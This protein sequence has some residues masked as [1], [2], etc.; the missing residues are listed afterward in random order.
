MA[1]QPQ[2][3]W[4]RVGLGDA[5]GPRAQPPGHVQPLLR[6]QGCP[7]PRRSGRRGAHCPGNRWGLGFEDLI[8]RDALGPS[9]RSRM[10]KRLRGP[11]LPWPVGTQDPR[12][13]TSCPRQALGVQGPLLTLGACDILGFGTK[14]PFF[15]FSRLHL[16][17]G[18]CSTGSP[19]HS[20]STPL[21]QTPHGGQ[22]ASLSRGGGGHTTV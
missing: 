4:G 11:G 9:R 5:L 1:G 17:M 19:P 15:E 2:A 12:A 7:G 14:K 3:G 13:G 22:L 20:L 10:R 21:S 18:A 6:G 8:P 16:V